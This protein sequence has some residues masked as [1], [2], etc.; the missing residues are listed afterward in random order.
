M[1]FDAFLISN[2]KFMNVNGNN[3]ETNN[4]NDQ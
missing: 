2:I 1:K 4:N 3:I